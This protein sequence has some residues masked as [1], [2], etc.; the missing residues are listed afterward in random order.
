MGLRLAI[1]LGNTLA[2]AMFSGAQAVE[3]P[4][5][6]NPET[7]ESLE[8][9]LKT[10]KPV[11]A[12]ISSVKDIPI[13]LKVLVEKYCPLHVLSHLTPLPFSI[14]YQTPETLGRDRI[15]AVAAAFSRFPERNVLVV[16][17]GTCITYDLLTADGRYLGGAIS[18]GIGMRLRAMNEF[19]SRLPLATLPQRAPL[20]GTTTLL[21]LQSGAVNGVKAE[22]DGMISMFEENYPELLVLVGGGDNKY[23]DSKFKNSIFVASNLVLEGLQA[24]MDFNKIG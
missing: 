22:L 19:T 6:F 15:A 16:D 13:P 12:M 21:S 18:P 3:E 4:I 2:K 11:A 7:P 9:A 14:D 23:F 1:D 8:Q 5:F 17:M 10:I 20:I 24:I